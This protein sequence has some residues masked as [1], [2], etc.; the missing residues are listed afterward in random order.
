MEISRILRILA[1]LIFVVAFIAVTV[2]AYRRE[3]RISSMTTLS[4]MSSSVAVDLASE[5][6]A[7]IDDE[8]IRHPNVI[9]PSR[10]SDVETSRNVFGENFRFQV[11]LL[12]FEN[13]ERTEI[14]PY[15]GNKPD[16]MRCS[17][18]LPV[19]VRKNK[20]SLPAKL[21]VIIWYD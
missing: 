3:E 19:S 21:R 13:N 10:L 4:D 8:G 16:E 11:F 14:G 1:A 6:L 5:E 15:G 12:C 2:A 17:F 9:D 7:W 18:S 20:T